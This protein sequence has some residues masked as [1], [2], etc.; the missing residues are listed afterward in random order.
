M[1]NSCIEEPLEH[2]PARSHKGL[3]ALR[4]AAVTGAIGAGAVI[5]AAESG[6][7]QWS[8]RSLSWVLFGFCFGAVFGPFFAVA[9]DSDGDGS[10]G[11]GEA[12][13]H[14]NSDTSFEGAQANDLRRGL[15]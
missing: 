11:Q 8:L 12:P 10:S 5:V 9:R 1:Y 13:V 4:Y 14:G 6:G 3:R 15:R 2:P 7:A